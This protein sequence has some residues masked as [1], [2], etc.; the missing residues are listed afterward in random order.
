MHVIIVLKN[1]N[2]NKRKEKETG[3][4]VAAFENKTYLETLRRIQLVGDP[5]TP[6]RCNKLHN[7]A[8]KSFGKE[9]TKTTAMK[10]N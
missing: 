6:V 9:S 10:V 2:K 3:R 1:R 4:E 7:E 5:K 8:W